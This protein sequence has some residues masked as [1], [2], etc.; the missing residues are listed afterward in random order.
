MT[1][2]HDDDDLILR[3]RQADPDTSHASMAAFDREAMV[4]SAQFAADVH[5]RH[6]PLA[7]FE[8][9]EVWAQTYPHA[10]SRHLYRQARSVARD[11]GWIRD[12]GVRKVNP[13]SGRRQVVW[14]AV[15]DGVPPRIETCATCG[16]VLRRI[17]RLL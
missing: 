11:R 17:P 14:E 5:R 10:C 8:F 13:A 4:A 16:H 3:A 9:G 6:G 1:D 2:D 12:S 7:D 15:E